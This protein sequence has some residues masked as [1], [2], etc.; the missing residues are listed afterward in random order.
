MKEGCISKSLAEPEVSAEVKELTVDRFPKTLRQRHLERQV[1]AQ[2]RTAQLHPLSWLFLPNPGPASGQENDF[3]YT[4]DPP[5]P[6]L[7]PRSPASYT[8][9]FISSQAPSALTASE[10]ER[11]GRRMGV[12][13]RGEGG[14]GGRGREQSV[15]T[16]DVSVLHTQKQTQECLQPQGPTARF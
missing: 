16:W 2:P 1:P 11:E 4:R 3:D 6:H 7:G 13:G 12:K 14:G 10:G 15:R 5:W 8:Y 9:K